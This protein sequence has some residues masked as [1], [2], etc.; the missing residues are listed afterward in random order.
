M[1]RKHYLLV[2][3]FDQT[4]SF[5][6]SGHVMSDMLGI[7]DFGGRVAGLSR[8]NLV[9]SGAELTYLILHDPEF[10]RVRRS[11]LIE[12]GRRIR[13]KRNIPLLTSFLE[14][15]IDGLSDRRRRVVRRDHDGNAGMRLEHVV[16]DAL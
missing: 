14:N 15:G 4:L 5:N 2:S 10:R 11:D 3:D 16:A 8:L 1:A 9:Q 7:N 12:V 13:L 6:D